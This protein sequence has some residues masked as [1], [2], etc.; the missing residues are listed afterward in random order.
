[1]KI[2]MIFCLGLINLPLCSLAAE[3]PSAQLRSVIENN[4]EDHFSDRCAIRYLYQALQRLTKV[5]TLH[6][7]RINAFET[8]VVN[9]GL[10]YSSLM[11]QAKDEFLCER[12]ECPEA[13]VHM[14]LPAACLTQAE[15]TGPGDSAN[16]SRWTYITPA[17]D[18]V[19]L[20]LNFLKQTQKLILLQQTAPNEGSIK[21]VCQPDRIQREL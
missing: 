15:E 3:N 4:H 2:I 10:R 14:T 18:V 12:R 8:E 7:C 6:N 13:A 5:Q 1:M 11:I 17:G 20:R 16:G 9:E 19:A 21:V